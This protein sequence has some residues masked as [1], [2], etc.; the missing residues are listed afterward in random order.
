MNR[1]ENSALEEPVTVAPLYLAVTRPAMAF[2]VTYAALLVNAIATV[3]LFLVTQN[4][5]CL[6]VSAPI[7][8]VF[9][10]L[11][12]SEPRFFELLLLWGRTRGATFIRNPAR[13]GTRGYSP[14]VLD[15]PSSTSRRASRWPALPA[16][17]RA[18]VC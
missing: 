11:C 3:E 18:S 16:F 4:L 13:A 6:L 14:L 1:L 9:V 7:H 15:L 8:G 5:L 12:T 17:S 2:G 10:L